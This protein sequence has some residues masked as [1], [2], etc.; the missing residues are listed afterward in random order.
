MVI[1]HR[2]ILAALKNLDSG[3]YIQEVTFF[4]VKGKIIKLF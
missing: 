1:L 4:G 3:E 2:G